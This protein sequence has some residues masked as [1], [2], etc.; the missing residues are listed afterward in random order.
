MKR[1]Y[2]PVTLTILLSIFF[3]QL[4]NTHLTSKT[5]TAPDTFEISSES[6]LSNQRLNSTKIID[7]ER[8]FL[9]HDDFYDNE[10][11]LPS[12]FLIYDL[13]PQGTQSNYIR[14][15][16]HNTCWAFASN[17]LLELSLLK[18]RGIQIDFSEDHLILGSP[19]PSDYKSGG[20]FEMAATYYTSHIGPV[21]E[22][23]DL[24]D[25]G[26]FN[27]DAVPQFYVTD[28]IE[29]SDDLPLTKQI[30]YQYGGA[31]SAISIDT[32]DETSEDYN[33]STFS[34]Y[35]L[36]ES[37]QLTH[38]ILL[39]GWD[40]DYDASLFTHMPSQ[41][42]AFIAQ[43]SWGE[44]WGDNGLF[45]ISYDD[46]NI[47]DDINAITGFSDADP[48]AQFYNYNETGITHFE[49]Y[50]DE[51]SATGMNTFMAKNNEKLTSVS[52]YVSEP[53]TDFT[54][55]IS[56]TYGD[57]EELIPV[58]RGTILF[59]GYHTFE[60]ERPIDLKAY[61]T[62]SI[63]VN[64]SNDNTIFLIPVEAPY[65]DID[66][67]IE[68]S[69]GQSFI[70]PKTE[71]DYFEDLTLSRPNANIGIRAQTIKNSDDY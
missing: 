42:G 49:G 22:S 55:Y 21:L 59:R 15:Q 50:A 47:L 36:D 31:V 24:Y 39:I 10:L 57:S 6:A 19:I 51:N 33:E 62:F 9:Y 1:L 5:N 70:A 8:S 16:T 28:Y 34:Y 13:F 38:E 37:K 60:L 11:I 56:H 71:F 12:R 32:A 23:D 44:N 2:L 3:N 7:T 61:E 29:V 35:S 17:T 18:Q 25:D 40:D 52:F 43:N 4:L 66:Y 69:E 67:I 20:Y 48:N 46:V 58:L 63:A 64:L 45:Y 68:S 27:N 65:Q 53:N 26:I 41:N 54:I 14:T 30:I